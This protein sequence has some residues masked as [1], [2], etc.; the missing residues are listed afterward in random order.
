MASI[1]ERLAA[2]HREIECFGAG[3]GELIEGCAR[4]LYQT[5]TGRA[6]SS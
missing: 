4:I 3:R 5:V 6:A 2:Y 1:L